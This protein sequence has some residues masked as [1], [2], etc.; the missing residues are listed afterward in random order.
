[1]DRAHRHFLSGQIYHTPVKL[2]SHFTGRVTHR[3][4]KREFLL[5]YAKDRHR[6][7]QWLFE[8]KKRY[9]LV[10]LNYTVTSNHIHLLAYDSSG[11]DVIPRSMQLVAGRTGQEYNIRKKRKGSFWEDRYHATIIEDGDL[12]RCIVYIDLNMVRCSGVAPR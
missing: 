8:A 5:K 7:L 11:L 6:W 2:A 1:M 10:I 9:G 3:C 12:L 4:H